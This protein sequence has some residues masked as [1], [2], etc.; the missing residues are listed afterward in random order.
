MILG[1][2]IFNSDNDV[3]PRAQSRYL[4]VEFHCGRC[5]TSQVK[6]VH[7]EEL[8]M[9]VPDDWHKISLDAEQAFFVCDKCW[10]TFARWFTKKDS[11]RRKS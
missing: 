9:M 1:N 4:S 11:K 5:R 3:Q 10:G 6:I 2:L 8:E 7:L